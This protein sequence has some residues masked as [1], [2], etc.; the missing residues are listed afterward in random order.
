MER[1]R[2]AQTLL[3]A[4]LAVAVLAMS[5]GFAA[6]AYN[7]TL[8]INGQNVTAKAAKWS[9]HYDD[10]T[11]HEETGSVAASSH[12][13][14]GTSWVFAVTLEPGQYYE[15]TAHV[16]NDGTFDA[17]LVSITMGGL[18]SPQSD[19]LTYTI[20][21]NG[22]TYSASATGLSVSLPATSG[23]HTVKVKVTYNLAAANLLPQTDQQVTLSASLNYESVVQSS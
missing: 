9:V 4:V 23:D 17:K 6:A 18:A 13:L 16:V 8:T 1:Q 5:I 12:T 21:Y 11:Y 19:Y 20:D 15:A 14:T 2:G 10:T 22:T 7:Q 3:I